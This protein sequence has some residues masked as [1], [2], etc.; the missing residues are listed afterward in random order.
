M[1]AFDA[2]NRGNA[3]RIFLEMERSGYLKIRTSDRRYG[4]KKAVTA[5]RLPVKP[6][7][8][9]VCGV[10]VVGGFNGRLSDWGAVWPDDTNAP[11]GRLRRLCPRWQGPLK[12]RLQ[13]R[14]ILAGVTGRVRWM[15]RTIIG[16]WRNVTRLRFSG[17]AADGLAG[18]ISDFG[19]VSSAM[20]RPEF[21]PPGHPL[22]WVRHL[23]AV[24]RSIRLTGLVGNWAGGGRARPS[25]P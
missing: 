23:S 20:G 5:A 24:L 10:V 11:P 14:E 17:A 2:N 22:R 3:Y 16:R 4:V 6:S 13:S 15:R 8:T 12:G 25:A 21:V 9:A 19:V 7:E 1:P 18:A